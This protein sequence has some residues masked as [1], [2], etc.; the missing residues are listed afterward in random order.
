MNYKNLFN[1]KLNGLLFLEV[2]WDGF[3]KSVGIPQN[4]KLKNSEVYIPISSKYFL[5]SSIPVYA[6]L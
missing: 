6:G 3:K 1:E 2:K 4:I 5:E